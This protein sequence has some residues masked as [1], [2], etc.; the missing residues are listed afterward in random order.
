[1]DNQNI[2]ELVKIAVEYRNCIAQEFGEN[3]HEDERLKSILNSLGF[4]LHDADGIEKKL[5][6]FNSEI[7]EI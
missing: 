6:S 3:D 7:I 4:D 2:L 5:P 1:M